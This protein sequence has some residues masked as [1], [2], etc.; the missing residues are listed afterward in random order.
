M[1]LFLE[2]EAL[3]VGGIETSQRREICF[4]A[5]EEKGEEEEKDEELTEDEE[6]VEEEE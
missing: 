6:V 4:E 3:W 2:A 1:K 5:E